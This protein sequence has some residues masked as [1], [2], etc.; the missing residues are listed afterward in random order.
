MQILLP[1]CVMQQNALEQNFTFQMKETKIGSIRTSLRTQSTSKKEISS[2]SVMSSSKSFTHRGILLKVFHLY[3][4]TAAAAVM[5]RWAFSPETS[6]S[7]VISADRICSKKLQI[8]KAQL[9]KAP[10]PCSI[11][12]RKWKGILILLKFGQDTVLA[13]HVVNLWGL[14]LYPHSVMNLK[15]TGFSTMTTKM[16]SSK[17]SP[18][19][20]RNRRLILHR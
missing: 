13:V 12:Y 2:M 20:S 15:I 1:V 16:P 6:Y 4:Q 3:S 10:I 18:V 9:K 7:S 17:N 5:N 8:W 11:L 19:T 14:C